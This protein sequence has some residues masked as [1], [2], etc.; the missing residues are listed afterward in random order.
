[1]G[2]GGGGGEGGHCY[3]A[4]LQ[5]RPH[6]D[7]LLLLWNATPGSYWLPAGFKQSVLVSSPHS[8]DLRRCR[9]GGNYS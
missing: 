6:L 4:R 2:S 8:G 5:W 7:S 1:M 9:R 3:S